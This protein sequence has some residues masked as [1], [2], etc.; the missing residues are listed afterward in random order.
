MKF[1]NKLYEFRETV[2][3]DSM[4]ILEELDGDMYI[5]EL[6]KACKK[7]CNGIQEFLDALDVLYALNKIRFD[8]EA[9]RIS[10]VK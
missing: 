7:K 8:S 5:L 4:I 10:S 2:I 6:Y 3:Y 9:R 1:P